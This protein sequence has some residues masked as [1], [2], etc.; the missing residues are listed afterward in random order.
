MAPQ[1]T[2]RGSCGRVDMSARPEMDIRMGVEMELFAQSPEIDCRAGR[3]KKGH[4]SR[5]LRPHKD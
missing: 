2:N 4:P 3:R 1:G 5:G